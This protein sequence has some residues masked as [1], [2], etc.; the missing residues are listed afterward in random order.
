MRAWRYISGMHFPKCSNFSINFFFTLKSS[1][2]F[3][4][5]GS[6]RNAPPH[7]KY[8]NIIPADSILRCWSCH[9]VKG[10]IGLLK[11]K[12]RRLRYLYIHDL[13]H[14]PRV[15]IAACVLHKCILQ[16]ESSHDEED[17]DSDPHGSKFST[18]DQSE[19]MNVSSEAEVK[20]CYI[21][22]MLQ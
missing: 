22:S 6:R 11:G 3:H 5:Q 9:D 15:I 21:A 1:T 16:K 4:L 17:I 2:F 8:A 20:R 12:W 13:D 14:I 7:P 10:A 19:H 18:D